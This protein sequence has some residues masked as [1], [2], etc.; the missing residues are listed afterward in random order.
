MIQ[1]MG[2]KEARKIDHNYILYLKDNDIPVVKAYIFESFTNEKNN[3]YGDL[4]LAIVINNQTDSFYMQVRILM[5]RR[6]INFLTNLISGL[7]AYS[8]SPKNQQSN[9]NSFVLNN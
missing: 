8:F 3:T 9:T 1:N 7:I 5:Y 6:F 4:D 2:K